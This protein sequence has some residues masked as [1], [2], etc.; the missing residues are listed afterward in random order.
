MILA[1]AKT[2]QGGWRFLPFQVKSLLDQS[3]PV[4]SAEKKTKKPNPK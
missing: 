1:N 3:D 2:A 4:K